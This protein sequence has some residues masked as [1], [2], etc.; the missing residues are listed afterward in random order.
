MLLV[1]S[2]RSLND[3]ETFNTSS[4][5][6]VPDQL[7]GSL[8][9]QDYVPG[10]E[11]QCSF[12]NNPK[13][14]TQRLNLPT[15]SNTLYFYMSRDLT[16]ITNQTRTLYQKYY[17]YI[18]FFN[19]TSNE[20]NKMRSVCLLFKFERNVP[21][22]DECYKKDRLSIFNIDLTDLET[23]IKTKRY[24]R[25]FDIVD[26]SECA[27]LSNKSNRCKEYTIFYE[28]KLK[29]NIKDN[30]Q[31][32]DYYILDNFLLILG[33]FTNSICFFVFLSASIRPPKMVFSGYFVLFTLTNM[34]FLMTHWMLYARKPSSIDIYLLV[35]HK[36]FFQFFF[37]KMLT[38]FNI[39][40]Y[41][42]SD[43]II[44]HVSFIRVLYIYFPMKIISFKSNHP[45]VFH[46]L[47][48]FNFMLVIVLSIL[49]FI[50]S[51]ANSL[52]F[53]DFL[54]EKYSLSEYCYEDSVE[55]PNLS[56]IKKWYR[57]SLN[58]WVMVLLTF[59]SLAIIFK[60]V[61]MKSSKLSIKKDKTSS[62]STVSTKTTD[63]KIVTENIELSNRETQIDGK[64]SKDNG[65]DK[66]QDDTEVIS[67]SQTKKLALNKTIITVSISTAFFSFFNETLLYLSFFILQNIFSKTDYL[68]MNIFTVFIIVREIHNII[69]FVKFSI[70]SLL[71]FV[72]NE[73]FKIHFIFIMK[74][75]FRFNK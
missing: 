64:I 4:D 72:L 39:M 24:E 49:E 7:S 47:F 30:Y 55:W 25:F 33:L 36:D 37:C 71:F 67:K 11:F 65:K 74:K 16:I 27:F 63:S 43:F 59:N 51:Q 29:H 1:N 10:S 62:L 9:D 31:F 66:N 48:I 58:I 68:G 52:N 26:L 45:F 44:I 15:Q 42:I 54:N 13:S 75:N 19:K 23:L 12:T 69:L 56:N 14:L 17:R 28:Y 2:L 32:W 3:I 60:F 40:A 41:F 5:D 73:N 46:F 35:S 18:D 8:P 70:T 61:H 50:I 22:S 57:T 34:F 38:G 20:C 21:F 53:S 6:Q